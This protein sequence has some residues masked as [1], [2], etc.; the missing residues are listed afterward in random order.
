MMV[1]MSVVGSMNSYQSW[2]ICGEPGN[3]RQSRKLQQNPVPATGIN[4][5]P[6]S[7]TRIASRILE[8][9]I[10]ASTAQPIAPKR[11]TDEGCYTNSPTTLK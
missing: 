5:V 2:R 11:T 1:Q 3:K 9:P 6:S 10:M 8:G 7:R 4:E